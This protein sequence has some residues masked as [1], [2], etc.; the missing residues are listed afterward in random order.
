MFTMRQQLYVNWPSLNLV[1]DNKKMLIRYDKLLLRKAELLS[2]MDMKSHVISIISIS[3]KNIKRVL[4]IYW[5]TPVQPRNNVTEKATKDPHFQ[6][7]P[8]APEEKAT[9][10]AR[11]LVNVV[12]NSSINTA[13]HSTY[14]IE[15]GSGMRAQQLMIGG[16]HWTI[17][18]SIL[19]TD[20]RAHNPRSR[21]PVEILPHQIKTKKLISVTITRYIQNTHRDFDFKR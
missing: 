9:E 12:K 20:I 7:L 13:R 16:N 17:F 18:L 6:A 10:Y 19:L 2:A 21:I 4:S 14:C 3:E 15:S 8:L 11:P 5:A 1:A